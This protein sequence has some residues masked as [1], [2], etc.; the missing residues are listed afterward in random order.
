MQNYQH[1]K[2]KLSLNIVSDIFVVI[3]FTYINWYMHILHIGKKR[4]IL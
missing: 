2:L 3:K 1:L 4:I